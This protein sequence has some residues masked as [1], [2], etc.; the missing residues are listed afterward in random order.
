M[1]VYIFWKPDKLSIQ[2]YNFHF[3]INFRLGVKN[4]QPSFYQRF[5]KIVQPL[6][7]IFFSWFSH[8]SIQYFHGNNILLF[9]LKQMQWEN[10]MQ[11]YM[12]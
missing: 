4:Y 7:I 11:I 5:L 3:K 6:S 8:G 1:K 2:W 9:C 12:L 10:I